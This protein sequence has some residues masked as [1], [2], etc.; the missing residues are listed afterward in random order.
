VMK[1]KNGPAAIPIAGKRAHNVSMLHFEYFTGNGFSLD[2]ASNLTIKEHGLYSRR[3]DIAD[4]LAILLEG[5][6]NSF[7]LQLP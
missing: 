2:D 1:N 4:P 3:D 6:R 5:Y 7:D